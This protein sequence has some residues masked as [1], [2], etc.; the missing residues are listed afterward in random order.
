VSR[1]ALRCIQGTKRRTLF[2]MLGWDQY[3]FQKKP[4]GTRYAEHVFLLLMRYV[5]LVVHLGHETSMHYF[6]CS[7]G[8]G[9]DCTKS[10]SGH[11]MLH[12]CF[13]NLCDLWA[14]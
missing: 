12:L 5:G 13:C 4:V 2:F 14:T 10:T 8:T 3:G 6:T 11:V 1:S 9:S 7:G